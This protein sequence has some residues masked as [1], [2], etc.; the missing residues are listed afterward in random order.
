MSQ[1]REWGGRWAVLVGLK[2]M[3]TGRKGAVKARGEASD[4]CGDVGENTR[5]GLVVVGDLKRNTSGKTQC[6]K[7]LHLAV[8]LLACVCCLSGV[9]FSFGQPW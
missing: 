2:E 4:V 1:G 8:N 3:A 7:P 9:P 6:S 5:C